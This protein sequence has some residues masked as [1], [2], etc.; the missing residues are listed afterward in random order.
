MK[1]LWVPG[2]KLH[3]EATGEQEQRNSCLHEAHSQG[4]KETFNTEL[5]K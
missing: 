1:S 2:I 3:V 4:E 5:H